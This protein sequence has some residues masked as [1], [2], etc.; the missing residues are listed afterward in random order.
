MEN[1]VNML[2]Y[3]IKEENKTHKWPI[4]GKYNL[5]NKKSPSHAL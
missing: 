1:Y 5:T 2:H 3:E 4:Q